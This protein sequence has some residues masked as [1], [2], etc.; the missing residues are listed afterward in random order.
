M[1]SSLRPTTESQ[2]ALRKLAPWNSWPASRLH[3]IAKIY[4]PYR[5]YRVTT[6]DR[7]AENCWYFAVDAA[8]GTLDPY[9][10]ANVPEAGCWAEIETRNCHPVTVKESDTRELAI[11][12]VR[13]LLF[14]RGFFRLAY[15]QIT[16]ELI[17]PEF[18]I[19]YWVGFCGPERNLKIRVLD[20]VRQTIEGNKVRQ[21]VRAWLLQDSSFASTLISSA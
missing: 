13:R 4:I 18:Y 6:H 9:Q 21:V 17:L 10:F 15:P 19:P 7:H 5:M 3:G 2:Y 14:S 16:A 8:A 20:A 1:I 12:K 11:E